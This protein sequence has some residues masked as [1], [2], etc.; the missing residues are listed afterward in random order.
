LAIAGRTRTQRFPAD[1][2]AIIV[3]ETNGKQPESI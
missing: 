3:Y 1:E 2:G